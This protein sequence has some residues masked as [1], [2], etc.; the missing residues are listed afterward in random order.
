M[1]LAS[2]PELHSLNL[3][4]PRLVAHAIPLPG[5]GGSGDLA[6]CKLC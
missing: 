1:Q 4:Y 6:Y 5:G 3:A 2:Y